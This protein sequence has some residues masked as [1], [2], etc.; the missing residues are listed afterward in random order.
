VRTGDVVDQ[1]IREYD[2]TLDELGKRGL[3]TT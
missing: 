2:W 1:I 3:K